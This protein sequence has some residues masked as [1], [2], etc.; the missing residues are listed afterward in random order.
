MQG[1][2]SAEEGGG[3]WRRRRRRRRREKRSN[4]NGPKRQRGATK[5]TLQ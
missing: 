5:Q 3:S 4:M 2:R 1:V